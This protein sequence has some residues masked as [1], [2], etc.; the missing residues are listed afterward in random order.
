MNSKLTEGC[1]GCTNPKCKPSCPLENEIPY[2]VKDI[3]NGDIES[4]KNKLYSKNPFPL[5]TGLFCNGYCGQNC[6]LNF[7]N[8]P[9]NFKSLELELAKDPFMFE[10]DNK[11][12]NKKIAI[13]G[14]GPIGMS[15]AILLKR[16]G[17]NI[18]IFEK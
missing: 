9:Y 16:S 14:A 7:K 11:L 13:I 18:T 15:C 5:L 8:K 10:L 6:I 2:I 17:A 1:I 12:K 4:A 3:K